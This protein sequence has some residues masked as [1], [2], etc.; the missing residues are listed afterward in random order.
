M[1]VVKP[2]LPFA[3]LACSIAAISFTRAA[4][5][6]DFETRVVLH[7]QALTVAQ[8]RTTATG[9]VRDGEVGPSKDAPFE[10]AVPWGPGKTQVTVTLTAK[11]L[12]VTPDGEAVL[13]LQSEARKSGRPPLSASRELRLAEE[14]SGL[15][16]IFGESDRRILLA[17]RGEKVRRAVVRPPLVV[18]APVRFT[19][20][21]ERVEGDRSVLLETNELHTFVGQSVEYSFRSGQDESLETVR[22]ALLP[23]TISGDIMT[24]EASISGALPGAGGTVLLSRNERIAASRQSVSPIAAL[25]GTPPAGYRFQVTPDF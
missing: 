17:I 25:A 15:F 10:L 9:A 23:S 11:L 1:R 5:S 2:C 22:L 4:P 18:G 3:L 19:V 16:E 21:V 6:V 14:G 13:M 7:V 20:A 12:S 24:I 8:D